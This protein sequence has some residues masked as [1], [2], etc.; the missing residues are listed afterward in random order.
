MGLIELRCPSCSA[1]LPPLRSTQVTC[2][3]CHLTCTLDDQGEV[4]GESVDTSGSGSTPAPKGAEAGKAPA[5]SP[6]LGRGMS[7][8]RACL[9]LVAGAAAI[10][11][12]V[13]FERGAPG[14]LVVAYA[15]AIGLGALIFVA[16]KQ[17]LLGVALAAIGG[18]LLLTKPWVQPLI[19]D[20]E[21]F[22]PTSETAC[23]FLVPGALLVALGLL[24]GLSLRRADLSPSSPRPS[25]LALVG[26]GAL[27]AAAWFGQPSEAQVVSAR[28][29]EWSELRQ[30]LL[31]AL[32]PAG[33]I[34]QEMPSEDFSELHFQDHDPRGTNTVQFLSLTQLQEPN[35]Q[36]GHYYPSGDDLLQVWRAAGEAGLVD[37]RYRRR[38]ATDSFKAE[39]RRAE[40]ARFVVVYRRGDDELEVF[41][42]DRKRGGL[43]YRALVPCD[44][45]N[46]IVKGTE[47]VLG[48][49]RALPGADVPP[50]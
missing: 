12:P 32:D 10:G 47:A 44:N 9:L 48:A 14:D 5:P 28:A 30:A 22:S 16:E 21:P 34:S 25:T 11:I 3:Y 20:G 7:L 26:I 8:L 15:I 4:A 31:S 43:R 49:L 38:V 45:P 39:V 46:G 40:T 6:F 36:A 17:K 18:G 13:A 35:A 37:D 24:V 42:F 29:Q 23:Y 1:P 2:D 19:R 50:D 27:L 41:L 33:P